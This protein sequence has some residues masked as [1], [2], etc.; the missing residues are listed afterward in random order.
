MFTT[1]ISFLLQD[2]IISSYIYI[3]TG[4]YKIIA[5]SSYSPIKVLLY[6]IYVNFNS[7]PYICL[8]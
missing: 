3:E 1:I 7:F 6:I 2:G 4:Y 8:I 5:V